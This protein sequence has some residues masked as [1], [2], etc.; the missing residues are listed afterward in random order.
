M[1]D[2][3]VIIKPSWCFWCRTLCITYQTVM[4]TV[5][6]LSAVHN[7][8]YIG[9]F[10][11]V[12]QII[13]YVFPVYHLI[14]VGLN[15]E[16]SSGVVSSAHYPDMCPTAL[17]YNQCN[18]RPDTSTQGLLSNSNYNTSFMQI[19]QSTVFKFCIILQLYL[20][21]KTIHFIICV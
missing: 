2:K 17:G 15:F 10:L 4:I 11:T 19:N 3:T 5:V 12:I 6:S 16:S 14:N 18:A 20:N 8:H 1:V 21:F 13:A 7:G 9:G